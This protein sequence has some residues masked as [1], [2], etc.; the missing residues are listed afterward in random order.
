M[1]FSSYSRLRNEWEYRMQM[2][3]PGWAT[4][5]PYA[6]VATLI[7]PVSVSVRVILLKLTLDHWETRSEIVLN[8]S[9]Q[10]WHIYFHHHHHHQ[11]R[12]LIFILWASNRTEKKQI[13]RATHTIITNTHTHTNTNKIPWNI[14]NR[15]FVLSLFVKVQCPG[16]CPEGLTTAFVEV[17]C[18]TYFWTLVWHKNKWAFFL[19]EVCSESSWNL[20]TS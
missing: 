18:N 15:L 6:P 10:Q 16:S 13:A 3:I 12:K 4:L 7:S 5:L 8:F 19:Y 14:R 2:M 20:Y 11:G 17:F 9:M 1:C